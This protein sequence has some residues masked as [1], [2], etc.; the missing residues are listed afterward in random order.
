MDGDP[1]RPCAMLSDGGSRVDAEH[2]REEL[3]SLRARVR[4]LEAIVAGRPATSEAAAFGLEAREK[5][6]SEAE[7]LAHVGSFV[8]DATSDTSHWS[9]ELHRI[10]GV[11]PGSV[12]PSLTL[13]L[14]AVD[15]RDRARVSDAGDRAVATGEL[16][17]IDFRIVR[18]DGSLRHVHM[19]GVGVQ[20][21]SGRPARFVGALLDVTDR[22]QLEAQLLHSRKMEALGRLA[23]GMAHDFNNLLTVIGMHVALLRR[24]REG[25]ELAEVATA[26]E[27]A[28][29]I[30]RQLL[31]FGRQSVFDP[32]CIDPAPVVRD[33][34]AM[35]RRIVG[36]NVAVSLT[37][38][39]EVG[40]VEL[41]PAQLGQVLMHLV[42]NASD[43]SRP[44][45]HVDVSLRAETVSTSPEGARPPLPPGEYVV[46]TVADEGVGIDAAVQR[47][48]FEPSIG[49]RSDGDESF[50]T[51]ATGLGLPLVFG[52]IVAARG[53]IVVQTAEGRGTTVLVYLPRVVASRPPPPATTPPVTGKRILLVEDNGAIRRVLTTILAEAGFDVE[54][55]TDGEEAVRLY[56][57]RPGEFAAVVTDVVM[58]RMGGPQLVRRLREITPHLP[59]LYLSGYARERAGVDDEAVRGALLKKPFLPNELV[60]RVSAMLAGR[61]VTP[62]A[63]DEGC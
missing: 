11:E 7:R 31:A 60:E 40:K 36:E 59:V 52:V 18:P 10:L 53:S 34:L 17:P 32:R 41:D 56:Q 35:A 22:V 55:A 14:A 62:R 28:A 45:G 38:D 3:E 24:Q 2:A 33:A 26:V 19:T 5:L 42:V 20:D 12:A 37:S 50:A 43:A 48:M 1:A 58:P 30:T 39:G 63:D 4:L 9:D 51:R 54:P 21:H 29:E 27:R 23:G 47:R 13:F 8:W 25:I 49:T 57:S 61:P 16:T 6:L 46:L 15:E 44:G